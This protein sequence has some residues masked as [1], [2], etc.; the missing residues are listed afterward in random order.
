MENPA[1]VGIS[2]STFETES[3]KERPV[4]THIFWGDTED[5]A[6]KNA[7]SHMMDDYFFSSTFVGKME[8]KGQPLKLSYEGY[9]IGIN[10]VN[11]NDIFKS[12]YYTAKDVRKVQDASG[13]PQ[14][15]EKITSHF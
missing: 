14:V 15:V 3:G 4:L 8:W 2:V 7:K 13:L 10:K 5:E 6:F 9:V 1:P 11:E 12:M